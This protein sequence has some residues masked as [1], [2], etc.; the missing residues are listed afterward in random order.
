MLIYLYFADGSHNLRNVN[1]LVNIQRSRTV[2][3]L[4]S[5]PHRLN[6]FNHFWLENA[7]MKLIFFLPIQPLRSNK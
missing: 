5:A 2:Y 7:L 6:T 4:E 1:V 3:V